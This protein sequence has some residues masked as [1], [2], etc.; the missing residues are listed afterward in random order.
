MLLNFSSFRRQIDPKKGRKTEENE[1]EGF[2]Q[3]RVCVGCYEIIV[4]FQK[5]EIIICLFHTWCFL[6]HCLEIKCKWNAKREKIYCFFEVI[7]SRAMDEKDG[8]A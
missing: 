3:F 6:F 2:I 5:F 8:S 7:P 1:E 4:L